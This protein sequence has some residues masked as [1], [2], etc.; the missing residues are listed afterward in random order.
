MSSKP[1]NIVEWARNNTTETRRGGSNKLEPTEELKNNGSLDGNYSLNHL[2][3]MLN[4]LGL[5]TSFTN[6]LVQVS[7]GNGSFLS[8][9]DHFCFILA[10]DSNN[11]NDYV[12]GYADKVGNN[13]PLLNTINSNNLSFGVT[14]SDGDIPIVGALSGDIKAF[15]MNF[16]IN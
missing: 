1:S 5:W 9:D 7:N 3:Y 2:N 4:L 8:K 13:A 10:F 12:F 14:N 11:I 15:S 16:K 6:D